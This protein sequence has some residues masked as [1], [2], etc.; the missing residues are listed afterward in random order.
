M[1]SVVPTW[2][3]SGLHRF[4]PLAPAVTTDS[5][6][7]VVNVWGAHTTQPV[8]TFRNRQDAGA[9]SLLDLC[10]E[11]SSQARYRQGWALWKELIQLYFGELDF[12]ILFPKGIAFVHYLYTDQR[13]TS[14]YVDQALSLLQH[15]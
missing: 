6:A 13:R 10:I 14:V 4:P 11:D 7:N 1:G 9:L 3:N 5:P 8:A 2:N 15:P 12:H